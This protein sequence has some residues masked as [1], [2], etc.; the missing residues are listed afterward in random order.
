MCANQYIMSRVVRGKKQDG[1]WGF[2]GFVS[3]DWCVVV[4]LADLSASDAVHST[5]LMSV[6]DCCV[7]VIRFRLWRRQGVQMRTGGS[8]S[9]V[10]R[11]GQDTTTH[12]AAR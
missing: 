11:R 3:S 1:G 7:A 8:I 4:R 2:T 12:L 10:V 6:G 5:A 9:K